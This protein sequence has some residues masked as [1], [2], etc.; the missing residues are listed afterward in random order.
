M[1]DLDVDHGEE[2]MFSLPRSFLAVVQ[3]LVIGDNSS[4]RVARTY[5]MKRRS[6]GSRGA[7]IIRNIVRLLALGSWLELQPQAAI[8]WTLS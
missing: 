2:L 6:E 5:V 7:S 1:L 3:A 4:S 8:D